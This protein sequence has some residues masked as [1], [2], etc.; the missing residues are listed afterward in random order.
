MKFICRRI[1]II[2]NLVKLDKMIMKTQEV[3]YE[4]SVLSNKLNEQ[5]K[6]DSKIIEER[7]KK[8][9]SIQELRTMNIQRPQLVLPEEKEDYFG[10]RVDLR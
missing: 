6:I 10:E 9:I 1:K 5:N 3:S 4:H 7:K 2:D 8:Q